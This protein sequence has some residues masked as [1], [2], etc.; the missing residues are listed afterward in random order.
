MIYCLGFLGDTTVPLAPL[1][2]VL[3]S[4][5]SRPFHY[6]MSILSNMDSLSNEFLDEEQD[7]YELCKSIC[8][9]QMSFLTPY[10]IK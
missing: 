10:N 2:Y 6:V 7:D 8:F 5:Q 1:P 9:L 3:S 4:S